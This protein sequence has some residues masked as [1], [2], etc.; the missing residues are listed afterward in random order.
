M[1]AAAYCMNEFSVITHAF[2]ENFAK[3]SVKDGKLSKDFH[4]QTTKEDLYSYVRIE[5]IN[6]LQDAADYKENRS[7]QQTEQPIISV[8]Y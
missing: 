6:A 5:D 3:Q 8:R 7:L 4:C 1:I 2:K